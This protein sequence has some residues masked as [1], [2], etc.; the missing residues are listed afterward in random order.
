DLTSQVFL[1]AWEKLDQYQPRGPFMSW[2]YVIAR[3]SVIDHYRTER[4]A[5]SLD[6]VAPMIAPPSEPD[7]LG[8]SG[9]D[10]EAI[11]AAMQQ[12]TEDQR[13]VLVMRFIAEFDTATIARRMGKTQGAVRALQMRA[14]QAL[15]RAIDVRDQP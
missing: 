15:A 7:P 9:F 5:I 10:M 2:L 1:K 8:N 14:L 13:E 4:P 12:L 11:Q 6:E 3:N